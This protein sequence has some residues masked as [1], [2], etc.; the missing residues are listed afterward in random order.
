MAAGTLVLEVELT[1]VQNITI[2]NT[3]L[4]LTVCGTSKLMSAMAA[5]NGEWH[6]K[7]SQS[8]M[9]YK[10]VPG[11]SGAYILEA[12]GPHAVR[13]YLRTPELLQTCY[14]TSTG[15]SCYAVTRITQMYG[16]TSMC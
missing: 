3:V 15:A 5:A 8:L 13:V 12:A 16:S 1:G 2:S 6:M 14:W 7:L 4:N 11:R 10:P 9:M